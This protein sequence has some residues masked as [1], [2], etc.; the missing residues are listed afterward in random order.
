MEFENK[1][2]QVL[3]SALPGVRLEIGRDKNTELIG[4]DVIWEGF[5]G[6][7][8]LKRQNRVYRILRQNIDPADAQKN[9]SYLF[10][11]TPE[12]YQE[13]IEG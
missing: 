6:Y 9:I 2:R 1:I 5:K 11:Y 8:S 7:Q 3:T 13:Y 12:E 10:T 4:G